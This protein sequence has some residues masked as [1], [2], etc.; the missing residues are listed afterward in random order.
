MIDITKKVF[1]H[2][3]LTTDGAHFYAFWELGYTFIKIKTNDY[4]IKDL[5]GDCFCPIVNPDIDKKQLMAEKRKFLDRV[6]HESVFGCGLAL[7]GEPIF[8]HMIWG[9]VGDDYIGSGYDTEALDYLVEIVK[10]TGW[11]MEI[12]KS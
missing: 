4:D 5:C 12:K 11:Q 8:E 10:K 3:N 7:N 6:R 1:K 2:H 9:F